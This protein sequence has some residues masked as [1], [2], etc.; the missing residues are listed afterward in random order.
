VAVATNRFYRKKHETN[1]WHFCT[2]CTDWPVIDFDENKGDHPAPDD[3]C[4]QCIQKQQE[5][6]CEQANVSQF[7]ASL[8]RKKILIIDDDADVRRVLTITLRHLNYE[9]CEAA[10]GTA[11]IR[12]S[13]AEN[14]DLILMDVSL[15]DSSGLQTAKRIKENSN[16]R[17]IPIVACSGWNNEEIAAQAA[18]AGVIEF[19]VKPI[20]PEQLAAVIEKLT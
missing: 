1:L 3:L 16:T 20:S 5:G 17:H 11:G 13:L 10:D 18:E 14:P 2:N 12:M 6:T 4:A 7:T 15:P 19:L 9:T 8:H